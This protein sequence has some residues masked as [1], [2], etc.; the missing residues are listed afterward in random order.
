MQ[1]KKVVKKV[2]NTVKKVLAKAKKP[3]P[4]VNAVQEGYVIRQKDADVFF[5]RYNYDIPGL[6]IPT[7]FASTT[8]VNMAKR[9]DRYEGMKALC[10][11]LNKTDG[12]ERTWIIV[13]AKLSTEF[14]GFGK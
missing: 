14:I 5:V 10:D 13:K 11:R 6:H 7:G 8:D 12:S 2:Q 4:M 3:T 1:T 9:G